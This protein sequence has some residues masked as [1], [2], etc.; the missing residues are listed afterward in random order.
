MP[1]EFI[2]TLVL[3]YG[4]LIVF[5]WSLS[6]FNQYYN[7]PHKILCSKI[8]WQTRSFCLQFPW[9]I[10]DQKSPMHQSLRFWQKHTFYSHGSSKPKL[11]QEINNWPNHPKSMELRKTLLFLTNMKHYHNLDEALSFFR[12]W[13]RIGLIGFTGK[14]PVSS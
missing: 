8:R 9:S 3:V 14:A 6:P 10:Q 7:F 1:F 12:E 5:L 13:H 4:R 2:F 11:S